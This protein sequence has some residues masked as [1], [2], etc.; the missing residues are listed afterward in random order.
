MRRTLEFQATLIVAA[1]S[2][3]AGQAQKMRVVTTAKRRGL[4]TSVFALF[5]VISCILGPSTF[6]QSG[7]RPNGG[8]IAIKAKE[9]KF[10]SSNIA[11]AKVDGKTLSVTPV[12]FGE[13]KV[14]EENLANGQVIG[15]LRTE[16]QGKKRFLP[17]G[18]YN[19]YVAKVKDRW[20]LYAEAG[21]KIVS[22]GRA[23]VKKGEETERLSKKENEKPM[24]L[25]WEKIDFPIEI[26]LS[27]GVISVCVTFEI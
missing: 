21:G 1:L 3:V 17:P 19:L 22:K 25:N 27:A 18:M 10:D 6:A 11:T 20:Y 14:T 26:C 7:G 4:M 16:L 5:L 2:S 13:R 8:E 9:V 24:I 23:S 15:L 12:D